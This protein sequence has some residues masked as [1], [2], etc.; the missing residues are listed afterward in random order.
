MPFYEYE[1]P[2]CGPFEVRRSINDDP[3]KECPVCGSELQMLFHPTSFIMRGSMKV[4]RVRGASGQLG[5]R[6][7][8]TDRSNIDAHSPQKADSKG[9]AKATPT[10]PKPRRT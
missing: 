5:Q 7:N 6:V 9:H 4:G 1:C 2:K 8:E 10:R 3:L